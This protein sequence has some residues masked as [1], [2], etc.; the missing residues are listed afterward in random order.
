[1]DIEE[2]VQVVAGGETRF[3]LFKAVY[4]DKERSIIF[5]HDGVR[6]LKQNN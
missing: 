4:N 1:M 2:R 5:V 3:I 6:C